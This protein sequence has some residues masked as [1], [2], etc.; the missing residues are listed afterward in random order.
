MKRGLLALLIILTAVSAR[1]FEVDY[2]KSSDVYTADHAAIVT[3]AGYF[4]GIIVMTDGTNA[5]T[6]KVYDNT[7]AS[8]TKILPD[9]L[10]T[11]G[12]SDRCQRLEFNPP[13]GFSTGVSV[14]ITTS[15]TVS[16]ML[17]TREK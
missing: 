13:L 3:G 1:A 14:D 5:V 10:V 16:Y 11:T 9:W 6:V 17:F 12:S 15:G 2:A 8:G 7:A 4:Y